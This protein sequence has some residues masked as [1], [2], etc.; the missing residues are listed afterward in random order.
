LQTALRA[1]TG[2]ESTL[3]I[4][5]ST[6]VIAGLFNPLRRRVQG[7]WTA[8]STAGSTPRRRP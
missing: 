4:V 3:A 6:L 8:A 7:W 1:L 5:A 2:Q